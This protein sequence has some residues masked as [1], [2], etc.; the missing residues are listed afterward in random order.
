M[1]APVDDRLR[2]S[3]HKQTETFRAGAALLASPPEILAIPYEGTTLP[4][5]FFRAGDAG[6]DRPARP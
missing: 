5:Y 4:G 3:A 2:S 6:D 1:G